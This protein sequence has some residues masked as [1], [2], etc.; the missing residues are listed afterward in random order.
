MFLRF[1]HADACFSSCL[2]L[3][4]SNVLFVWIYHIDGNLEGCQILTIMYNAAMKI[5]FQIFVWAYAFTSLG[6]ILRSGIAEL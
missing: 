3:L 1:I 4:L 2:F 6:W 5:C